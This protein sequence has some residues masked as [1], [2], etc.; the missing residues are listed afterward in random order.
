MKISNL[1]LIFIGL[2]I[3]GLFASLGAY[4]WIN[5]PVSK[6]PQKP[7]CIDN[8]NGY[9]TDV[10]LAVSKSSNVECPPGY[11]IAPWQSKNG[12]Q[13]NPS[14]SAV[15]PDD[16]SIKTYFTFCTKQ[17]TELCEDDL[18]VDD[19]MINQVDKYTEDNSKKCPKNFSPV[20]LYYP[21]YKGDLTKIAGAMYYKDCPQY[22]CVEASNFDKSKTYKKG[23]FTSSADIKCENIEGC[24]Y[25]NSS[26]FSCK[27]NHNFCVC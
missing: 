4:F 15:D 23:I 1:I 13:Y 22:L 11:K 21:T 12:I 25:K 8:K 2:I 5:K 24:K 16:A 10:K 20:D 9:I 27:Y 18:A 7:S 26:T 17:P 3:I 14:F 19:I 6:K